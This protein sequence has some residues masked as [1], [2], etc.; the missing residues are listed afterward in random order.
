MVNLF[1][2]NVPG[3]RHELT[4]LGARV[5][6]VLPINGLAGNVALVCSALSYCGRFDVVVTADAAACPDVDVMVTGR[7]APNGLS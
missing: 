1:V 3:P 6:E 7:C 4:L 5:E 2:T